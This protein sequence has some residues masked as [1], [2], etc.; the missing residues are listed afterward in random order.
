MLDLEESESINYKLTIKDLSDISKI[1]SPYTQTFK[2][3]STDKNKML[4]G[5]IGNEKITQL[6]TSGVFDSYLYISGF[7]FQSGVLTPDELEYERG[8]QK[9]ISLD[10]ASNLTSLSDKLGDLTIQDLFSNVGVYD[11]LVKIEWNKTILK[12]RMTSVKNYTLANGI[13]FKWGVP[14]MSNNRVWVYNEDDANIVDN[15][16]FNTVPN[17]NGT[18]FI[19][20]NEVRP[21]INYMSIMN[22]LLLKIGTP[23]ICPLFSKPEL[24]DLYVW[25]SSENLVSVDESSN[26]IINY[27]PIVE[28][29]YD[30][31]SQIESSPAYP[32]WAITGGGTSG[33]FKAK[34]AVS[35]NTSYWGD[36]FDLNLTFNNLENLEA[37]TKIKVVLKNADTNVVIDSQE[38]TTNKYLYRVKDS[39][40]NSQG[41][42]NFAFEVLPVTLVKWGSIE[43]KSIQS[44]YHSRKS[45]IGFGTR[46]TRAKFSHTALNYSSSESLG[47][48]SLNLITI[49]PKMKCTDFLK[50]FFKM[51]NIQVV[52]S[53]LQDNSMYWLTSSDVNETNKS[54][55]KRIVDWTAYVDNASLNKE[56][57]NKYTVYNFEHFKSDY[58]DSV[59]GDGTR[60]GSLVYPS[61]IPDK[62]TK[63][64]VQTEYSILK[65]SSVFQHP[66]GARTAFGF[67]NDPPDVLEN[68]ANRYSPVYDE[69]TIMYLKSVSLGANPV[70][71]QYTETLNNYLYTVLEPTFKHPT[72]G[73]TL[74]FGAENVNDTDSLY[75]NYYKTFIEML[76]KK[77]TFDSEFVLTLPPNEI[78]LNFANLKQGESNIPTGYRA[79]N[80]III[81]EQRYIQSDITIDT[82]TGKTKLNAINY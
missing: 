22:H 23:V 67:S 54:Y 34:R 39:I 70:A 71:S 50:S 52:S 75:L 61:V 17:V 38:I 73:K 32:K 80:E 19:S 20:L 69:F 51:F 45:G 79:Q 35:F 4:L 2:I 36:G 66:S 18:S 30:T 6:N 16:A 25:G 53:G 64:D 28:L 5:F 10:F 8:D 1:Y 26:K 7:L 48:N 81:G 31:V 63:F 82:T 33:I 47:G 15:I 24:M 59:F 44:Y 40:L 72:T 37:T 42:L 41:E 57:A 11:P 56:K 74:A 13:T 9:T 60:F 62:I 46:V 78:F 14:F 3:K 12:D 68:G 77:N 29:K 43:F 27:N 76:T 21:A 49:L 55:S 58:F 65:Q